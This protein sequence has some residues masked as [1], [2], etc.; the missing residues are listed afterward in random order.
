MKT[1]FLDLDETLIHTTQ[2]LNNAEYL[3]PLVS[4]QGDEIMVRFLKIIHLD[5]SECASILLNIPEGN[6]WIF[7]NLHLHSIIF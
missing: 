4:D 6:E 3:V 1:L 2:Q 7:W 5:W